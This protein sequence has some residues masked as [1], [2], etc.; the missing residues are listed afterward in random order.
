MKRFSTEALVKALLGPTLCNYDV[1]AIV[2][3]LRAADALID[4]I[5]DMRDWDVEKAIADYKGKP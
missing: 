1:A 2:A 5:E 4:A 3:K